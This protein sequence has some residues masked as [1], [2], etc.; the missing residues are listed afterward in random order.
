MARQHKD[1]RITQPTIYWA[2]LRQ[3]WA[4]LETLL[5]DSAVIVIRI[6]GSTLS[7]SEL[8]EGLKTTLAQGMSEFDVKAL[9]SGITSNIRRRE[10]SAF[11][12]TLA[13]E[14]VEHDFTFELMRR[15]A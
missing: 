8:F 7:K 10:I 4:G 3:A 12:P 1:D 11:R 15:A 2:F 6:G 9:T 5:A 13:K 14:R